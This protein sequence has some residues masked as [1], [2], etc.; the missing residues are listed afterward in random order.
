MRIKVMSE[1]CTVC[2]LVSEV[3]MYRSLKANLVWG[4]GIRVSGF[5]FMV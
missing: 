3:L 5:G 4:F 2:N 1:M